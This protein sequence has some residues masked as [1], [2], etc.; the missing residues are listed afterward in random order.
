M[1][2]VVCDPAKKNPIRNS[3][4]AELREQQE[5]AMIDIRDRKVAP[6]VRSMLMRAYVELQKQRN[7]E[8]MRP[9]PKPIDVSDK[10]KP[11][12]RRVQVQDHTPQALPP[13]A[14]GPGE[15]A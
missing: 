1:S 15:T 6:H 14:Q 13:A 3:V 9:A 10:R 12:R 2:P 4:L 8:R 11:Q 7:V 5:L